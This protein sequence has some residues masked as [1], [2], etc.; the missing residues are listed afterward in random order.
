MKVTARPLIFVFF[1]LLLFSFVSTQIEAQDM[2]WG[3][4]SRY[5]IV[6]TA[7]KDGRFHTFVTA[8]EKAG[9][10]GLM[11]EQNSYTLFL[12]TDEAFSHLPEGTIQELFKP[13]N[14]DKLTSLIKYHMIINKRIMCDC[15]ND[16][17]QLKTLNGKDL[18]VWYVP[19][20]TRVG[21]STVIARIT[22][23]DITT[24]NGIIH[25]IDE[26]LVPR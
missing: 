16:V 13:E 8:V 15:L 19:G 2:E 24:K 14:R 6:M 3:T 25:V 1:W 23:P 7:K 17:Y 4:V 26:V 20:R 22:E 12:P 10:E 11:R 21:H 5:D 9:M 18:A